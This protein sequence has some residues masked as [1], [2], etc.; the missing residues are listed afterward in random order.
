MIITDR[1][2]MVAP[3]VLYFIKQILKLNT[4]LMVADCFDYLTGM[5]K[6]V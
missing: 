5:H 6:G 1:R 2:P 4:E 3:T